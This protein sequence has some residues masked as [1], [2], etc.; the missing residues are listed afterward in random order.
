MLWLRAWRTAGLGADRRRDVPGA[1][2]GPGW[3]SP[4]GGRCCGSTPALI[5][6]GLLST[7]M[8]RA[9]VLGDR[10][11]HARD[12][13]RTRVRGAPGVRGS[14]CDL[15]HVR[16]G[17]SRRA[18][19]RALQR[20][21]PLGGDAGE[22]GGPPPDSTSVTSVD[23]SSG[24]TVSVSI[25]RNLQNYPFPA[26]SPMASAYPEGFDL[27]GRVPH[28]RH[29]HGRHAEPPGPLPRRRA[30]GARRPPR[31]PPR[32]LTGLRSRATRSWR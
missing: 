9:V 2:G 11:R 20:S 19:R 29:L 10:P 21:S 6:P 15:E 13:W 17:A 31:R 8:R 18:L 26:D 25:P 27:R 12:G 5:R 32:G 24:Q 16:G 1:H 3:P 14:Q 23:A 7:G 30:P 4:S 28:E 22:D